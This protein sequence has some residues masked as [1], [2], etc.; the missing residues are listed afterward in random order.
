MEL[1]DGTLVVDVDDVN[2][3]LASVSVGIDES[4]VEVQ[5]VN[6]DQLAL[7]PF[8]FPVEAFALNDLC[9]AWKVR[10]QDEQVQVLC[11]R[12]TRPSRA[13]TPQ[14]PITQHRTPF[15]SSRS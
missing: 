14:P 11:S 4:R 7:R 1:D 9:V 13:S 10:D 15:W 5:S 3:D 12:V 8:E 2:V 6:L